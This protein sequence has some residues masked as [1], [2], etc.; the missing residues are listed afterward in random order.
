[1]EPAHPDTAEGAPTEGA[2]ADTGAD[3]GTED[4]D[5]VVARL[6]ATRQQLQ[7]ELFART[8]SAD[9]VCAALNI[10]RR[11]YYRMVEEKKFTPIMFRNRVRVP[12]SEVTAQI[13]ELRAL[14]GIAASNRSPGGSAA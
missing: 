10:S 4:T 12:T 9:E 5:D 6:A 13:D 14:A 2:G 11:T 8:M 1:V 7:A 3:P